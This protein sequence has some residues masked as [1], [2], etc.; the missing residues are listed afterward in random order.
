MNHLGKWSE[1]LRQFNK[2]LN[3]SRDEDT[4][5]ETLRLIDST[6]HDIEEMVANGV[7]DRLT[8]LINSTR[9]RLGIRN[10]KPI[11]PIRNYNNF[12]LADDGALTYVGKRTVIDLGNINDGIEPPSEIR[13]LGN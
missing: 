6:K 7:Y 12:K 13:K 11:D 9:K 8:I 4:I 1:E 5:E 10:I 3:E 2:T